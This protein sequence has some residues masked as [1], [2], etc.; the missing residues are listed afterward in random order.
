MSDN[1][2]IVD[3]K[4]LITDGECAPAVGNKDAVCSSDS[5]IADIKKWLV[6]E[7]LDSQNEHLARVNHA[8]IQK[9]MA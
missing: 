8:Y 6:T 2:F 5:T 1:P 9:L 7:E 4:N 3:I